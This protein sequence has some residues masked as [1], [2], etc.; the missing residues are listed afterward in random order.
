MAIMLTY[1][2][3]H[4]RFEYTVDSILRSFAKLVIS[5]VNGTLLKYI[6]LVSCGQSQETHLLPGQARPVELGTAQPGGR[7][8]VSRIL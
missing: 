8:T 5:P 6:L 7:H 2:A 1:T 4:D 3:G